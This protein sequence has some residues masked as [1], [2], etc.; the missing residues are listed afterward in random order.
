MGVNRQFWDFVTAT[1]GGKLKT[2]QKW[3][4][5]IKVRFPAAGGKP[6]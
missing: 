3:D 4:R 6:G 2:N 5:H 1:G